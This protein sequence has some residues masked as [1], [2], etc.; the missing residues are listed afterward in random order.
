MIS[1]SAVTTNS[2]NVFNI[3][4]RTCSGTVSAASAS[5]PGL[6]SSLEYVHFVGSRQGDTLAAASIASMVG[7]LKTS[8]YFWRDTLRAGL[9][10]A[11]TSGAPSTLWAWWTGGDLLE[12]TRA[13][14]AM[15]IPAESSTIALFVAATVAHVSISIFWAS[16]LTATLPRKH[17]AIAA[18]IASAA[19]AILD[20]RIIGR[21]FPE[22]YA[23]PFW[24]QF[25]DHLAWGMTVGVVLRWQFHKRDAHPDLV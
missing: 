7:A 10:A 19:I 2:T 15:L 3:S 11:V 4:T 12:A 8:Q 9:I 5:P 17:T 16:A 6:L 20:L 13:A 21:M 25:A 18:V 1:A 24:P 22:I 14:G 23:L